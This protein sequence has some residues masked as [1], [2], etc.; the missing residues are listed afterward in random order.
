MSIPAPNPQ[1]FE[2]IKGALDGSMATVMSEVT[3]AEKESD[4]ARLNGIP[5]N[6]HQ[7][8]GSLRMVELDAA[9]MLAED[10]ETLC[11]SICESAAMESEDQAEGIRVL[12]RG[13]DSLQGYIDSVSR[14]TPVSPLSLVD[15]INQ[16]RKIT[17]GQ[18]I[19]KLELFDPPQLL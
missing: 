13:L 18:E 11:M 9:G 4:Y 3:K 1:T 17:G 19:S 7:I 5:G 12:R 15:Q 16:I 14:Q 2:W 10:L 6:L 8:H